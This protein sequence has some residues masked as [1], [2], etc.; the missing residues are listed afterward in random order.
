[1]LRVYGGRRPFEGECCVVERQPRAVTESFSS[2]RNQLPVAANIPCMTTQILEKARFTI[3]SPG[4]LWEVKVGCA[5]GQ[6]LST[7]RKAAERIA[8]IAE[9]RMT[10]GRPIMFTVFRLDDQD[11]R[12][13]DASAD[14]ACVFA[15]TGW[16]ASD[17]IEQRAQVIDLLEA[18][19]VRN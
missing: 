18:I 3:S 4:K 15:S 12:E 17:C 13:W 1:M 2:A 7:P 19:L 11:K 8:A 10:Q 16:P 9:R 5:A 14:V 6:F